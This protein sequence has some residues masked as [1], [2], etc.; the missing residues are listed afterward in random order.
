MDETTKIHQ[1]VGVVSW[2]DGCVSDSIEDGNVK[3]DLIDYLD[4]QCF[5]FDVISSITVRNELHSSL[6]GKE[7]LSGCLCCKY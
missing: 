6:S 2:G 7:E 3:L 4:C 5:H 1:I